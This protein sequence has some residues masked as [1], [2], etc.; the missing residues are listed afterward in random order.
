MDHF[1]DD[2]ET[3]GKTLS[4]LT[5]WTVQCS[6][7]ASQALSDINR[8]AKRRA[9]RQKTQEL[10]AGAVVFDD[11]SGGHPSEDARLAP[12]EPVNVEV[13]AHTQ[14]VE[15]QVVKWEAET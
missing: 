9:S 11:A 1:R 8:L 5:G 12:D 4:A 7:G 14:L 3:E 13:A 15:T 10:V 2:T 6:A